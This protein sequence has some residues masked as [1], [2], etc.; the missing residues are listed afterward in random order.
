VRCLD[1]LDAGLQC[2]IGGGG[3][4]ERKRPGLEHCA[5]SA[6]SGA[7]AD[8]RGAEAGGSG[9]RGRRRAGGLRYPGAISRLPQEGRG[10]A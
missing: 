7:A 6:S 1:F 3:R 5:F 2:P 10:R 9:L 4:E 8:A